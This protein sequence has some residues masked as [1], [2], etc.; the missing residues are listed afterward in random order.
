MIPIHFAYTGEI[1]D[2]EKVEVPLLDRTEDEDLREIQKMLLTLYSFL[3]NEK[4]NLD[5]VHLSMINDPET[6]DVFWKRTDDGYSLHLA[7]KGGKYW[8]QSA[9]QLGYVLMHCMIDRAAPEKKPIS[10]AEELIC[11]TA[12]I[13]VLQLLWEHWPE[14]TFGEVDPDYQNYVEEYMLEIFADQGSY[15]LT[16]CSDREDLMAVNRR[17]D[18]ED[19]LEESHLLCRRMTEGDLAELIQVRSFTEDE[20]LLQTR[21][22]ISKAKDSPGVAYLCSLQENIPGCAV[23]LGISHEV[24]VDYGRPTPE[25]IQAYAGILRSL[26]DLPYEHAVFNFPGVSMNED[27]AEDEVEFIQF[28]RVE[29]NILNTEIRLN[30]KDGPK[31]YRLFAPEETAV[32]I[33][34]GYLEQGNIPNFSNWKD[35][36]H[37][38]LPSPEIQKGKEIF[39]GI[40]ETDLAETLQS[41]RKNP[42]WNQYYKTAPSILCKTLIALEYYY[43]DTESED[44]ANAMDQ[45]EESLGLEDWKH[46][47]HYCGNNPRKGKI[48][49]KIKEL[50]NR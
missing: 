45:V 32:A 42:F 44:A 1:P 19:R 34:K 35:I 27:S 41:W 2:F 33:L 5:G 24:S 16:N 20:L 14:T 37:M 40:F 6:K 26:R 22:W 48:R 13:E 8:C 4:T 43:S 39:P 11:E 12:A 28:A 9:Y 31:L 3:R 7:I 49:R 23:H 17:N 47:Y 21:F 29:G 46:L 18:F 25:L 15:A 36:T 38:I 50:E 10:W 30:T